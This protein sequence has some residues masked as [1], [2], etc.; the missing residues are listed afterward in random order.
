MPHIDIDFQMK[1]DVG[2]SFK[3]SLQVV[4][5]KLNWKRAIDI[6]RYIDPKKS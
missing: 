5:H 6:E 4:I 1:N 3:Y 2:L